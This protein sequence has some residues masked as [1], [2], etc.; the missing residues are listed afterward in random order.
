MGAY[1]QASSFLNEERPRPSPAEIMR[2][3]QTKKVSSAAYA[4]PLRSLLCVTMATLHYCLC[5]HSWTPPAW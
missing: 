4:A 2:K 3:A 5:P 1:A